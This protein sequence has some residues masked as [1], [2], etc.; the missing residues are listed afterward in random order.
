MKRGTDRSAPLFLIP[1]GIRDMDSLPDDLGLL[2]KIWRVL[3]GG[4]EGTG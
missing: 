2:L 4:S 1:I 3:F